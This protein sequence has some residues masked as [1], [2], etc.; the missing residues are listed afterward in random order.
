MPRRVGQCG[1]HLPV[2][3]T[4]ANSGCL[5]ARTYRTTK[6]AAITTTPIVRTTRVQPMLDHGSTS[7]CSRLVLLEKGGVRQGNPR[8]RTSDLGT[9]RSVASLLAERPHGDSECP[10]DLILERTT[11]LAHSQKPSGGLHWQPISAC[12][13]LLVPEQPA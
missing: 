1:C 7:I 5:P 8:P 3:G 12:Q 6:V 13:P 2:N 10:A 11:T 9:F 4:A